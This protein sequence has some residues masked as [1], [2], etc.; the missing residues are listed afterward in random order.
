MNKLVFWYFK[1]TNKDPNFNK[2]AD[3]TRDLMAFDSHQS[4]QIEMHYQSCCDGT[5]QFGA[6]HIIVGDLN[7]I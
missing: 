7:K 1:V 5:L 4:F 6:E 3:K 2:R